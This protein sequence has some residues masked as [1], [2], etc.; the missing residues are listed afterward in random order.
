MHGQTVDHQDVAFAQRW[1]QLLLDELLPR[2]A[3]HG[4]RESER[5]HNASRSQPH[6]QGEVP[7]RATGG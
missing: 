6:H 2:G 5:S 1:R 7:S 3:I 4:A